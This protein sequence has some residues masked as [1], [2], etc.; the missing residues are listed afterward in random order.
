MAARSTVAAL[1]AHHRFDGRSALVRTGMTSRVYY[2]LGVR[3][4][5]EG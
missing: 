3:H 2:K 5:G 1:E 4:F